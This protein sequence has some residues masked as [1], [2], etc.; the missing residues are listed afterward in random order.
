MI[1]ISKTQKNIHCDKSG[2]S[3]PKKMGSPKKVRSPKK[4]VGLKKFET[5]PRNLINLQ[6][7]SNEK[8]TRHFKHVVDA[9]MSNQEDKENMPQNDQVESNFKVS[10]F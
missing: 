6:A 5:V 1:N 3:S 2:S 9:I 10:G 7:T 8:Q 4:L